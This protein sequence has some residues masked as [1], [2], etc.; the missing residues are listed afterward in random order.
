MQG[1][2]TA[3]PLRLGFPIAAMAKVKGW[4]LE[5]EEFFILRFALVICCDKQ[6]FMRGWLTT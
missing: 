6:K 1:P 5:K 3:V 2:L 4:K